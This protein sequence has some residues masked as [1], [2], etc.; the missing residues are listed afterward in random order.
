MRRRPDQ[1]PRGTHG[2][3]R[4]HVAQHQRNRV[5]NAIGPAVIELGY[6]AT[7][8]EILRERAGISRRTF[9]DH[10]T[11]KEDAVVAFYDAA[12][13]RLLEEIDAAVDN[14]RLQP[15]SRI[16]AATRATLTLAA[17]HPITSRVWLMAPGRASE[18]LGERRRLTFA[19]LSERLEANL[20]EAGYPS[21]GPLGLSMSIGGA[22][23]VVRS[24]LVQGRED[25]LMACG[26]AVVY[27]LLVTH[28]GHA[29]AN[30]A[31]LT[32]WG[33]SRSAARR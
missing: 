30:R 13:E 23:E 11:D 3:G 9:Y 22:C 15:L 8:V 6:T 29:V 24:Q 18:R 5:L 4:E 28:T 27:A 17:E 1:L 21:A 14:P 19:A 26:P 16:G 20:L 25:D 10:F 32:G 7:T 2:L 31:R 33:S 12:T